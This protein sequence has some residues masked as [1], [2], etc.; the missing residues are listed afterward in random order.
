MINQF[1]QLNDS[2]QYA[3]FRVYNISCDYYCSHN[4]K[5]ILHGE[6]TSEMEIAI[7][8]TQIW[9]NKLFYVDIVLIIRFLLKMFLLR[10]K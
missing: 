3:T 4:Q 8:I 7:R 9:G 1:F 5:L 2:K 6:K 10:L